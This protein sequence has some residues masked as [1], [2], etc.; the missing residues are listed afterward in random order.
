MQTAILKNDHNRLFKIAAGEYVR[1]KHPELFATL[2]PADQHSYTTVT[3]VDEDDEK[4]DAITDQWVKEGKLTAEEMSRIR[5][6][7]MLKSLRAGEQ[8][9]VFLESLNLSDDQRKTL[10]TELENYKDLAE[11]EP[12]AHYTLPYA[13]TVQNLRVNIPKKIA[14]NAEKLREYQE[15]LDYAD[16]HLHWLE[17]EYLEEIRAQEHDNGDVSAG[18]AEQRNEKN[19]PTRAVI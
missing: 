10:E 16:Q 3:G 12:E 5:V 15:A 14:K 2:S 7:A 8:T 19:R 1:E 4:A 11:D 17:P 18:L 6:N 13:E 9:I